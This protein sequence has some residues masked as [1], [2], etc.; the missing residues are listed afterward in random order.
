M[1][2]WFSSS[3]LLMLND[4]CVRLRACFCVCASLSPRM[5]VRVM[6][7]ANYALRMCER[8]HRRVLWRKSDFKINARIC[9]CGYV[10]PVWVGGGV[11]LSPLVQ[12]LMRLKN[13]RT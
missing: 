2:A 8:A 3:S 13:Q 5:N 11:F 10:P 1:G 4:M 9:E 6:R 7:K 12:S